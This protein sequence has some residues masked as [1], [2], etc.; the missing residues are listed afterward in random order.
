VGDQDGLLNNDLRVEALRL[1]PT[2]EENTLVIPGANHADFGTYGPQ[3]GD[4][5]SSYTNEEMRAI[6]TEALTTSVLGD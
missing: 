3:P 6:I 4:G 2:G 1:L 5:P